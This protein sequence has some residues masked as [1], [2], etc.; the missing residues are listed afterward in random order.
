MRSSEGIDIANW[1]V[2]KSIGAL[3]IG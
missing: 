3:A 1:L 2:K